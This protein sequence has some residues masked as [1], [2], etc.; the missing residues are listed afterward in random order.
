MDVSFPPGPQRG[1]LRGRP[2]Y[3]AEPTSQQLPGQGSEGQDPPGHN[4]WGKADDEGPMKMPICLA[5]VG[6][7]ASVTGAALGGQNRGQRSGHPGRGA[8]LSAE[9]E[10]A[11]SRVMSRPESPRRRERKDDG[12]R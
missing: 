8:E 10:W 1:D 11:G 7:D 12:K 6:H 9:P 5:T 4:I 2:A 3:L